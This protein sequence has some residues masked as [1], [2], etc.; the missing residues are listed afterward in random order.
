[1]RSKVFLF[2]PGSDVKK[3]EKALASQADS[4]ILDLED[5]VAPSEKVQARI[6]V[7]DLLEGNRS[8]PVLVRINALSTV[9]ALQDLLAVLPHRPDGILLPKTESAADVLMVHWMMDQVGGQEETKIYPLIETAA[10]VENANDIVRASNRVGQLFFGALDYYL[11]LGLSYT[12]DP[13]CALYAR[14]R[15][16]GASVSGKLPG[17]IDTVYPV[18]KDED[19]LRQDCVNAKKLGFRGKMIIHPVQI[20]IVQ[21]VF[22][23]SSEQIQEAKEIVEIYGKA[24]QEGKGAIQWK[25]KM[26]DEPVLRRANQ[27][28]AEVGD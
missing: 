1:M 22:A 6:N 19:G 13:E 10:G 11:D 28:L 17:P 8:K 12:E 25:G 5:A 3:A 2:A 9:W 4:V 21:E 7:A 16:V 23:P 20:P 27:I 26:L 18:I 14:A 15:L 24:Q